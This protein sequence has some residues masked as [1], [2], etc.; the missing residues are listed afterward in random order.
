MAK[1]LLREVRTNKNGSIFGQ[2]WQKWIENY[3]I[4]TYIPHFR[5]GATYL[6]YSSNINEKMINNPKTRLKYKIGSSYYMFKVNAEDIRGYQ[7]INFY[8]KDIGNMKLWELDRIIRRN[9]QY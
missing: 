5:D 2:K 6:V 3:E 7:R 4:D 8:S 9:P 1:C